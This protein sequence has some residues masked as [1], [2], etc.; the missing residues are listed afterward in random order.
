MKGTVL[1]GFK[2]KTGNNFQ[3]QIGNFLHFSPCTDLTFVAF[4]KAL[5]FKK[6]VY[7]VVCL[8]KITT[9]E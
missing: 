3:Y 6:L 2:K 9:T 5:M 7:K 8:H 4:D 1:A